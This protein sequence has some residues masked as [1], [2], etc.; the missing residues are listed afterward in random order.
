LEE[1][2]FPGFFTIREFLIMMDGSL[3]NHYFIRDA[4]GKRILNLKAIYIGNED[5]QYQIKRNG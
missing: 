1:S 5:K 3:V 4:V 2:D